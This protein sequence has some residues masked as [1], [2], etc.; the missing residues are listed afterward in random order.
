MSKP[1]DRFASES[2]GE[3]CALVPRRG[4]DRRSNR[5][6]DRWMFGEGVDFAEYTRR[7]AQGW[8]GGAQMLD[9][10]ASQIPVPPPVD[11]R[12]RLA[13]ADQGAEL[14]IHRV[15]KGMLSQAWRRPSQRRSTA[16]RCVRIVA[17]IAG[18]S[19]DDHSAFAWRGAMVLRLADILTGFG[20]SVEI[21]GACVAQAWISL[22]DG[23]DYAHTFP[24][25]DARA[26]LDLAMLAAVLCQTGFVRYAMFRAMMADGPAGPHCGLYWSSERLNELAALA[27]PE[28]GV[29]TIVS[30]YHGTSTIETS[31]EWLRGALASLHLLDLE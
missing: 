16:P 2:L 18:K 8:E 28:D 9:T 6:G 15:Y 11:A 12:R 20:Y 30:A 3:F 22:T 23:P 26:P 29:P 24:L 21:I 13:W 7:M 19:A 25:K 31:A 14:D 17:M 10:L 4:G 1:F 5:N 27:A